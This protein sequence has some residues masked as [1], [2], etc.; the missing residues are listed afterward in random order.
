[1]KGYNVAIMSPSG[2][3]DPEHW[4]LRAQNTRALASETKDQ[5]AK[6]ILEETAAAYERLAELAKQW[7]KETQTKGGA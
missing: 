5:A 2:V 7:R 4:H 1:L 6:K 3:N